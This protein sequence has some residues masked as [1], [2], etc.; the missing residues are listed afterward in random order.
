MCSGDHGGDDNTVVRL[1]TEPLTTTGDGGRLVQ[2]DGTHRYC[3]ICVVPGV[4]VRAF[5]HLRPFIQLDATLCTHVHAGSL[6]IV[7]GLCSNG[8]SVI[9]AF[10]HA[11]NESEAAWSFMLETAADALGL[12]TRANMT[13]MS[14]CDERLAAAVR[15][16]M[17]AAMH[18]VCV[19][20]RVRTLEAKFGKSTGAW[21]TQLHA[22]ARAVTDR[23]YQ[24]AMDMLTAAPRGDDVT[25]YIRAGGAPGKEGVSTGPGAE[26]W[27]WAASKQPG[28]GRNWGVFTINS[29]KALHTH[30]KRLRQ[31]LPLVCMDQLCA[32]TAKQYT[33]QF[34]KHQAW[35]DAA[36][37][38]EV[39]LP[40]NVKQKLARSIRTA[41]GVQARNLQE[42]ARTGQVSSISAPGKWHDVRIFDDA[43]DGLS[44]SCTC[45][46]PRTYGIPCKHAVRLAEEL[47]VL[48]AKLVSNYLTV[49]ASLTAFTTGGPLRRVN[50]RSRLQL[51]P[52]GTPRA[53]PRRRRRKRRVCSRGEATG[54]RDCAE[55]APCTN[56][57]S[58][59]GT[60]GH[61]SSGCGEEIP[62]RSALEARATL[63]R[64][65]KAPRFPVVSVGKEGHEHPAALAMIRRV[66]QIRHYATGADGLILPTADEYGQLP[67]TSSDSE[68]EEHHQKALGVDMRS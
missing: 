22:A 31:C 20:H 59:C 28:P 41:P 45:N 23:R 1:H 43:D 57:C 61:D 66:N 42:K 49:A 58:R 12:R 53:G 47:D 10:G 36:E 25:K 7:L 44:A 54:A 4:A 5:P 3:S 56:R 39:V 9:L 30:L 26:M 35:V 17:P 51:A 2:L 13:V 14:E 50:L 37:G 34:A 67:M 62:A 18:V 32:Y 40:P 55:P 33:T 19:N 8:G 27:Q 24:E 15:R 52:L 16:V 68:G 63:F 21:Q 46:V 60:P 64:G 38:G 65:V 48:P 29:V 11:C 6:F